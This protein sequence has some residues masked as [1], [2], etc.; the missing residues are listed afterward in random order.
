MSKESK[1][2][3]RMGK[4]G[5]RM[6]KEGLRMSREGLRMSKNLFLFTKSYQYLFL[7]RSRCAPT[8]YSWPKLQDKLQN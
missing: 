3:L 2:G 4:E 5:L 1:E 8:Q 7:K 6:S